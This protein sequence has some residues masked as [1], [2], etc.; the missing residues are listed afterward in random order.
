MTGKWATPAIGT[1]LCPKPY[2]GVSSRHGYET[3]PLR[4]ERSQ[5]CL[6]QM[7]TEDPLSTRIFLTSFSAIIRDTTRASL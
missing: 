5:V 3:A 4:R 7:S 2:R 1:A 6:K